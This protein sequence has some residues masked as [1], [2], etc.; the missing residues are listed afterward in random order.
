MLRS[1]EPYTKHVIKGREFQNLVGMMR[2]MWDRRF[3]FGQGKGLRMKYPSA[4]QVNCIYG[5]QASVLSGL[6]L[7]LCC[8]CSW[9][10]FSLELG[11]QLL[12]GRD[13]V[14]V[15]FVSLAQIRMSGK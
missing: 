9:T 8:M 3:W 4:N 11:S 7:M 6:I 13:L 2:V 10:C 1:R 5:H 12:E 14:V 15:I